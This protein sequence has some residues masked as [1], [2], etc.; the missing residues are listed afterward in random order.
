MNA[1][2]LGGRRISLSSFFERAG[3]GIPDLLDFYFR[4]ERNSSEGL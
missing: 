2:R 3:L 1:M 4:Y